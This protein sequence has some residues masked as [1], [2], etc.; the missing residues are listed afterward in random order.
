MVANNSAF[1]CLFFDESS[2]K[3]CFYIHMF[4]EK[5][6]DILRALQGNVEKMLVEMTSLLTLRPFFWCFLNFCPW[7]NLEYV[8]SKY[9]TIACWSFWINSRCKNSTLTLLLIPESRGWNS[10]MRHILSILEGKK[11]S[12]FFNFVLICIRV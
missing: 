5:I 8:T 9:A 1:V 4:Q 2:W 10:Y 6:E 11:H 3:I 12:F 7:R